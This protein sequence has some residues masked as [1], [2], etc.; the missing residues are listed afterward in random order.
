[1]SFTGNQFGPVNFTMPGI[2]NVEGPAISQKTVVTDAVSS[3]SGDVKLGG[4]V[5]SLDPVFTKADQ[6]AA[7]IVA[8]ISSATVG[9]P[10]S[11]M[12]V[13]D[14]MA[15]MTMMMLQNAFANK[16]VEREMRA[17]LSSMQFQ[18]GMKLADMIEKRGEL[19]FKK[20]V[21]SAVTQ[22]ASAVANIAAQEITEKIMLR[23]KNST[24]I[25]VGAQAATEGATH[26][27]IAPTALERQKAMQ[28]GQLVGEL[29]KSTTSCIGNLI[30]ANLDLDISK[31]DAEQKTMETMN[32]LIDN[33]ISSVDSSIHSQESA[34]QFAMNM[35]QQLNSLAAESCNRIINNMR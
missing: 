10:M 12:S 15:E 17:E 6:S 11:K 33:I 8:E 25:S 3:P 24:D 4:S 27:K 30:A 9:N 2:A 1:M 14:I 20:A 32:K 22:V 26:T 34:I 29:A 18:N 35:L 5:I 16:S 21:T 28:T 13:N 19:A 23:S 7:N 31:I